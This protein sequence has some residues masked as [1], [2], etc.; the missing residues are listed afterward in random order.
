MAAETDSTGLIL[1]NIL[2][3]CGPVAEGVHLADQDVCA[4]H[5]VAWAGYRQR[6]WP[7]AWV[8]LAQ[9]AQAGL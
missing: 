4:L 1:P 8:G 9:R 6:E 3:R 7:T 2:G 5:G